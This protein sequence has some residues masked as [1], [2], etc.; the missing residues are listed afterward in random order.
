MDKNFFVGTIYIS[1]FLGKTKFNG[2]EIMKIIITQ[3]GKKWQKFK[4]GRKK[5]SF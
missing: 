4:H 3:Q 2:Q 5:L 1:Q